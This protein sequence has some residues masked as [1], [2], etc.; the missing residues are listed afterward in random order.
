M[1]EPGDNA[2]RG[3]AQVGKNQNRN[4]N[5]ISRLVERSQKRNHF[6]LPLAAFVFPRETAFLLDAGHLHPTKNFLVLI[7]DLFECF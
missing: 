2:R 5:S 7:S 6:N 4:Q 3:E 1:R